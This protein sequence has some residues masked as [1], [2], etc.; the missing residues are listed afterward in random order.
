MSF[1][2]GSLMASASRSAEMGSIC[3]SPLK[4][5]FFSFNAAAMLR[6]GDR[7][8]GCWPSLVRSPAGFSLSV[9]A[10]SAEFAAWGWGAASD[11]VDASGEWPA[12]R[13]SIPRRPRRLAA[14]RTEQDQEKHEYKGWR[15]EFRPKS[16]VQRRR[17]C[18]G[19]SSRN[20][21]RAA[22]GGIAKPLGAGRRQGTTVEQSVPL[23]P[24]SV[25]HRP[26][27]F[28]ALPAIW[29]PGADCGKLTARVMRRL[30]SSF[31]FLFVIRHFDIHHF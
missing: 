17:F 19:G 3:S 8:G 22:E 13:R 2:S 25:N 24:R 18:K 30:R 27:P 28:A 26:S 1:T 15:R 23:Q 5:G 21:P 6:R 16:R 31:D 14:P 10:C 12:R 4:P 20:C 11:C 29:Q 9:A 7:F